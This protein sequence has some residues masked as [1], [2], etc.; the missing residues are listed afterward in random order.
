M[1]KLM[2][3]YNL[4][5]YSKTVLLNVYCLLKEYDFYLN[6]YCL[7]KEFD[8]SYFWILY[9]VHGKFSWEICKLLCKLNILIRRQITKTYT[10]KYYNLRIWKICLK[11]LKFYVI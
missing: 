7:L 6:A 10:H 3:D 9:A 11:S 1:L 4:T 8:T 5:V 2:Y